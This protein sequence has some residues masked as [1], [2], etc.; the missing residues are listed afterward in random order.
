[1]VCLQLIMVKPNRFDDAG[2]DLQ[3]LTHKRDRLS[4]LKAEAKKELALLK[5]SR[6]AASEGPVVPE[7]PNADHEL[8]FEQDVKASLL[9]LCC[10]CCI[11]AVHLPSRLASSLHTLRYWA[12]LVDESACSNVMLTAGLCTLEF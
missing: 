9:F 6:P 12:M 3:T 7:D 4:Q 5:R 1:M 8:A 11:T 2:L 10:S